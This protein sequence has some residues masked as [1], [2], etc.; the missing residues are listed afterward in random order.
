MSTSK[1]PSNRLIETV[2]HVM[3]NII[4]IQSLYTPPYKYIY[5]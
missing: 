5:I 4:P 1:G 2:A 3:P